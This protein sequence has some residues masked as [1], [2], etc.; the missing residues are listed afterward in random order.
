MVWLHYGNPRCLYVFDLWISSWEN[1]TIDVPLL[2]MKQT[3]SMGFVLPL[4]GIT[5]PSS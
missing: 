3:L 5:D 1:N 4:Q 2:E